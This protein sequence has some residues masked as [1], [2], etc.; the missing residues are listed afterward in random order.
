MKYSLYFSLLLN[1]LLISKISLAKNFESKDTKAFKSKTAL[2]VKN[3]KIKKITIITPA[4]V[5]ED[6]MNFIKKRSPLVIKDYSGTRRDIAELILVQKALYL[7][8]H[9]K[10]VFWGI[11]ELSYNRIKRLIKQSD[12]IIH[13]SGTSVWEVDFNKEDI[14]LSD[15]IIRKGE[16]EAGIYVKAGRKDLL[17]YKINKKTNDFKKLSFISSKQWS[18]DWLTLKKFAPKALY[19]TPKWDNMV[20]MVYRGR[21]DALLAPFQSGKN[22]QLVVYKGKKK[23]EFLPIKGYKIG[24]AGSR[25][26]VLTKIPG[27]KDILAKV[28][29]GIKILRKRGEVVRAYK[30]SGFFNKN[31]KYWQVVN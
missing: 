27:A 19:D 10:E 31:T 4:D 29:K 25:H 18:V 26:F 5:Y 20:E 13:I 1:L 8:G 22:M 2:I 21:A 30:Q 28:N 15:A 6:Y 3:E 23:R 17:N 24:L 16:F 14:F 11:G 12:G 9:R 7:G